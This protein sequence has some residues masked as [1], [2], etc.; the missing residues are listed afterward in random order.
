M[1][2]GA[3]WAIL[4]SYHK[5]NGLNII[6]IYFIILKVRSPICVSVGYHQVLAGQCSSL[7]AL[8]KIMFPCLF[9]LRGYLFSLVHD[10]LFQGPSNTSHSAISLIFPL[11]LLTLSFHGPLQLHETHLDNPG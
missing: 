6:K 8:R 4:T 11:L 3:Y 10:L 2:K 7:E 1:N 9:Q 5:F